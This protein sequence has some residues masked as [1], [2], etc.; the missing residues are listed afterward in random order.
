M[1]KR[2]NKGNTLLEQCRFLILIVSSFGLLLTLHGQAQLEIWEIQGTGNVSPV[3]GQEVIANGN[4]VTAVGD[5]YFFI[6]TPTDRSDNDPATSDGLFVYTDFD[7][8][9]SVGQVV[10][11]RGTVL[12]FESMTE[13][14]GFGL[15]F[16]PT[17]AT[18]PLPS[19]VTLDAS[20]PGTEAAEV[21][22]FEQVEGMRVEFTAPVV[23]PSLGNDIAALS[24]SAQRPFREA[25][26]L[27]PGVETLPVW[28]G[29]PEIFWFDPDALNQPNNRFLS[30][31]QSVTAN[32]VLFQN[33]DIYV[34]FPLSYS[35]D[36]TI[37]ERDLRSAAED[38]I[39]VASFNVLQLQDESDFLDIQ[40]PKIARY[41]VDRL[42]G[43]DIVA[44]QEV[45]DIGNLNE[46]NFRINQLDPDLRYNTY[47]IQGNNNTPINCA[48]LVH[49]SINDV[50]VSQ[51]ASTESISLGGRLHDRPPLLLEANLPTN[52][53]TPIQ[54]LNLHLRSLGGIEGSNSFFVRTKRHEQAI[55]VANLIQQ[56]Q[57]NNLIVVGDFNAFQFSDGY[58]DVLSQLEGSS[59]LGA[60]FPVEPVVSPPLTNVSTAGATDE[61][62][63]FVF[64]GSAQVLDHCL[65]TDLDGMEIT[66]FAYARGNAD[67]ASAYFL[68]PNITIRAS[69]HDGF[70]VYLRPEA[71][72]ISDVEVVNPLD[73]WKIPN[74]L[75]SGSTISIPQGWTISQLNLFTMDGKLIRTWENKLGQITLPELPSGLYLLHYQQGQQVGRVRIVVD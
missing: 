37:A 18:A 39:T 38:E 44:L 48:F 69:D 43:P 34:A 15:S 8:G 10:N 36:G 4:V 11:V 17:G 41:I 16:T 52:P 28:D 5:E 47:L 35:V 3:I 50:E 55:S 71:P 64:Q 12:E 56:R 51:L 6:Q 20:F 27:F 63:S 26:I 72:I 75:S 45:G 29:N 46:L 13:I 67:A 66:E 62:Y 30:V 40:Y 7:P 32:A 22:D 21:R 49:E 59:S 57:G 33:D 68:N 31:G 70:V 58:V 19:A 54:V 53:P 2:N 1:S 74:P 73:Q 60:L 14:S 9:L 23:A 24:T 25:G 65:S 61:S 42:G